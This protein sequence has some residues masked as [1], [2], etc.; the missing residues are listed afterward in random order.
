MYIKINALCLLLIIGVSEYNVRMF[1]GFDCITDCFVLIDVFIV[2]FSAA[3]TQ[4]SIVT[5]SVCGDS[6]E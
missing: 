4:C 1:E 2:L 3:V 5:E 6:L